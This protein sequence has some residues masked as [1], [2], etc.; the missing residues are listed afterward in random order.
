M[1]KDDNRQAH[2]YFK[3]A[4]AAFAQIPPAA[5]GLSRLQAAFEEAGEDFIAIELKTMIARLD[6][7]RELLASGPQG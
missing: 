4:E 7:L 6:E 5:E 3:H 2:P 1:T